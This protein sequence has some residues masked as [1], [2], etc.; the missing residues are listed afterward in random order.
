MP[1]L[2]TLII[3]EMKTI[4]GHTPTQTE[5]HSLS[6]FLSTRNIKHLVEL[7][8]AIDIDWKNV[9]TT[10]CAWCGDRFLNQEMTHTDGNESFCCEQCKKDYEIEHGRTK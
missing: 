6:E 4:L 8:M 9:F 10:E 2:T 7:E 3:N 1:T 5:M